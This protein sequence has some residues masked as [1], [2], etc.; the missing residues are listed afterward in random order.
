MH[1]LLI[2]TLRRTGNAAMAKVHDCAL[3]RVG[4]AAWFLP[5]ALEPS[6]L[7]LLIAFSVRFALFDVVANIAA[8]DPVFHVGKTA[9]TDKAL[10]WVGAKLRLPVEVLAAVL[11]LAGIAFLLAVL[12]INNWHSAC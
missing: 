10:Q 1:G 5:V 9:K 7:G 8:G 2:P 11:K 3:H 6:W 4:L 12:W